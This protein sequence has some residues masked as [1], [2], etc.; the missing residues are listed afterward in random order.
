M[1]IRL[2]GEGEHGLYGG[3]A[4]N[5]YVMLH[6]R[7]HKYFRRRELDIIL[8]IDINIAQAALG[9]EIRVPTLDGEEKLTIPA[10]TQ[11]GT[12]FR[13]RGKGVPRLRGT[14][15]GDQVIIV[16]ISVPTKLSERQRQLLMELG[17]TLGS[18]VTPQSGRG[19]MDRL[20]EAL[21]I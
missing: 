1:R 13:L 7:P 15:R 18:E 19:F 5:L 4:G 11:P 6:V 3:P 8:N 2:A 17:Q 21:G 12:V 9:D 20:K 10:G 14:G 16:N